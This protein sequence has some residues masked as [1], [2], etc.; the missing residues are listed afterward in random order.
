MHYL[1][2]FVSIL[3]CLTH[4]S[5]DL[6]LTIQRKLLLS[7]KSWVTCCNICGSML[8]PY[9]TLFLSSIW[10]SR[11]SSSWTAVFTCLLVFL[12]FMS[13]LR[14]SKSSIFFNKRINKHI[15]LFLCY[16]LNLL[17]W[18]WL[19]GSY[20]F[21]SYIY[22]IHD[23]HIALCAHHPEW[24]HLPSPYIWPPLPFAILPP[25]SLW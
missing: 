17:R 21:Q 11:L 14:P 25:P 10:H 8:C 19:M 1:Y 7:R 22:M 3:N 16:L 9:F 13:L 23:L 4:I 5:E 24:D 12:S 20:R 2:Y 15:C 18:H 6:I